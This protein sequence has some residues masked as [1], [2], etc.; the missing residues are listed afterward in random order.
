MGGGFRGE[1]GR[2]GGG[3]GIRGWDPRVG[4]RGREVSKMGGGII[5]EVGHIGGGG[6]GEGSEGGGKSGFS[7]HQK[8]SKSLQFHIV[9]DAIRRAL[10]F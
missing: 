2:I 4:I 3:G 6:G 7:S 10:R 5:G 1:V 9:D 8:V